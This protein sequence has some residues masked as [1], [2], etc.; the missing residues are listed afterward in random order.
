MSKIV[1]VGKAIN[2]QSEGMVIAIGGFG[3]CGVPNSLIHEIVNQS[4]IKNLTLISNNA[5]LIDYGIGKLITAERVKKLIAA[6]VGSNKLA[7]KKYLSGDLE[8]ELT[9]QGTISERLRS[10]GSGLPVFYSRAGVGTAIQF[11]QN[12]IKYSQNGNIFNKPK[13]TKF[14]NDI[15]YIMEESLRPDIALVKAQKAD[16]SGN[17]I[18]NLSARNFNI[19][20]ALAGKYVIA[21]AEEI[22]ESGQQ[23]PN[24]VHTPGIQIDKIV[25]TDKH[26]KKIFERLVLHTSDSSKPESDKNSEIRNKIARR[27]AKE[28]KNG[29]YVNIGIGIPTLVPK[30]INPE[31]KS[32]SHSE[33][34]IIG[35]TGFPKPG[36]EN[37]DQINASKETVKIGPGASVFS[38]SDSFAM[39]RSGKIDCTILGA[40]EVSGNGDQAN[41]NIP[42]KRVTGIGGAM[43]LCSGTV[44]NVVVTM[45]HCVKG[46]SKIKKRCE[47]PQTGKGVVTKIVT[48]LAVFGI[49]EGRMV[50]EEI[51]YGKNVEEVRAKTECEFDMSPNLGFF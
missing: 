12:V 34:G 42:G 8:L 21:E 9:P 51:A 37:P 10:G 19:D 24:F 43:D 25:K 45:E 31:I 46:R 7:Q 26:G 27:A 41:W 5:G 22:V 29:M 6:H 3:C 32:I 47:L 15:E 20:M 1:N 40:M 39:I 17:L 23:D 16:T 18:Y 4:H 35:V 30:Y 13:E 49:S 48:E 36:Q 38:S 28:I 11:G 33:N 44:Q 2:E 50:L 14:F